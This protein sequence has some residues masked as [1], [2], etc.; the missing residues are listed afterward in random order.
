MH[1]LHQRAPLV[2]GQMFAGD[3]VGILAGLWRRGAHRMS[4]DEAVD[5]DD[6]GDALGMHRGIE[7][8]ELDAAAE[9]GDEEFVCGRFLSLTNFAAASMSDSKRS[10][11]HPAS[12]DEIAL[13]RLRRN[14]MRAI[15]HRPHVDSLLGEIN[16]ERVAR[17]LERHFAVHVGA[18]KVE[19]DRVGMRGRSRSLGDAM[20]RDFVERRFADGRFETSTRKFRA[21]L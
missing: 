17:I 3:I 10:L 21:R 8:R 1:H 16:L 14:E 12:S 6:S 4:R 13:R 11:V 18:G 9:A 20:Q 19:H 7:I 5:R 2:V 15:V